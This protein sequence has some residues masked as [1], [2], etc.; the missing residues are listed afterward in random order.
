MKVAIEAVY[1]PY[2]GMY[3]YVRAIEKYSINKVEEVPR[4]LTRKFLNRGRWIKRFYRELRPKF[5]LTNYGVMHSMSDPW[6]INLC[7]RV[8]SRQACKWV[9]TYHALFFEEH[10][11]DGLAE[12][13][14]YANQAL[15][16][17]GRNADVKVTVS[18][19]MQDFLRK[20]YSIDTVVIENGIDIDLCDNADAGRFVRMYGHKD[21]ILFVGSYRQ[22]KDPEVFIKCARHM[23]E[24]KF[25]MVGDGID[26]VTLWKHYQVN[27]PKNLVLM[28]RMPY[29][30]VMDAMA[31]CKVFVMTSKSESFGFALCEA[32]AIGKTVVAPRHTGC[33]DLIR[34]AEY[35]FLYTPTSF[36]DLVVQTREALASNEDIGQRAKKRVRLQ[37]DWR[38]S[39][40]KLDELYNS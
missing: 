22:V 15:L 37:Y 35:G 24:V 23:P 29:C 11:K 14:V 12:W 31:A 10:Y 33:K 21:F 4:P 19:W 34:S 27:I 3:P 5:G 7:H 25:V 28:G 40:K 26:E 36:D 16:D 39:I 8:R 13:Q 9:Q 2:G 1:D 6:F 20:T 32:M 38:T 18:E 30:D 17:V